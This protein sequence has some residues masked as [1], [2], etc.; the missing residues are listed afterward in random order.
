MPDYVERVK[1][2]PGEP[3]TLSD[4]HV[5][6]PWTVRLGTG[7]GSCHDGRVADNV[8]ASVRVEC[9]RCGTVEVPLGSARLVVDPQCASRAEFACP[10]CGLLGTVDVDE[11][12]T[13]LLLAADVPLSATQGTGSDRQT[14]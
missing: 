7:L 2:R 6:A 5:A 9:V 3:V 12:A 10:R 1:A 14:T 8:T 4:E 11:R 13:R